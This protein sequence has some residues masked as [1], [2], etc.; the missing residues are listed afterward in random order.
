MWIIK[1]LCWYIQHVSSL[2]SLLK[3]AKDML[4]IWHDN[5]KLE[6][7]I[8]TSKENKRSHNSHSCSS[9]INIVIIF[10][11]FEA[12]IYYN[13]WPNSE[14]L[15]TLLAT[16]LPIWNSY[17]NKLS[18]LWKPPQ[19]IWYF[20][21][22]LNLWHSWTVRYISVIEMYKRVNFVTYTC[23]CKEFLYISSCLHVA[24]WRKQ[25]RTNTAAHSVYLRSFC[26]KQYQCVTVLL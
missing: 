5:K 13:T 22:F 12:T 1:F 9:W 6:T 18:E 17:C 10:F 24:K 11:I 21:E 23:T 16:G 26:S 14:T 15:G 25:T 3:L 4:L 7:C 20:W 19:P 8:K 2:F